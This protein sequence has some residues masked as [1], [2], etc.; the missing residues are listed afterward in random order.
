MQQRTFAE[1]LHCMQ[2]A[3]RSGTVFFKLPESWL[4]CSACAP[5]WPFVGHCG[6]VPPPSQGRFTELVADADVEGIEVGTAVCAL[7]HPRMA[8]W[9]GACK[10]RLAPCV[11]ALS[12]AL[13]VCTIGFANEPTLLHG[14]F[15][16]ACLALQMNE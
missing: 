2:V 11:M 1:S 12:M 5:C 6:T 3:R 10:Q 4:R 9:R 8:A 15:G 14:T 16:L 7:S 13:R